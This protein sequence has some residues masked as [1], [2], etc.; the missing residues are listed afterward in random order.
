MEG[1][2]YED[3]NRLG[4]I[5]FLKKEGAKQPIWAAL[6][7]GLCSSR[8]NRSEVNLDKI[9]TL[10]K[11]K[12]TV[13]VAGKVLGQGQLDHEVTVACFKASGSAKEKVEKAKGTV[14]TI[15]ELVAKNPKGT[16]VVILK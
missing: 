8:K 13:V 12:D 11:A 4:L 15:K 6:A 7:D 5:E 2:R 10:T 9:N 14:I 1:I 16:R 3:P